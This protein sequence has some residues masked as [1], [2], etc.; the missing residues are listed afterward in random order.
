MNDKKVRYQKEL[1]CLRNKMGKNLAWFDA[2]P[3]REQ[4][5]FL[6]LWKKHKYQNKDKDSKP[7]L[8]HFITDIKK[9][10]RFGNISGIYF[11]F[12]NNEIVYIGK[13]VSIFRR[14]LEHKHNFDSFS[15]IELPKE[16]LD[17]YEKLFILKYNPEYN[18]ETFTHRSK[19]I[20]TLDSLVKTIKNKIKKMNITNEQYGK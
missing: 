19:I 3:K 20:L 14:I 7:K 15:Y 13:S 16:K 8:R 18:T 10:N 9:Y 4:F 2:L 5:D 17:I 11:L 12:K 6:F 1:K